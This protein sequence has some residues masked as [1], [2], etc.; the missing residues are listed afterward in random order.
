MKTVKIAAATIGVVLMLT[1][2][3]WPGLILLGA[4]IASFFLVG[5]G[6]VNQTNAV[7]AVNKSKILPPSKSQLE[8]EAKTS[9]NP[10]RLASL[11]YKAGERGLTNVHRAVAANP[12]T[13]IET[14]KDIIWDSHF[15]VKEVSQPL[16]IANLQRRVYLGCDCGAPYR[17][18]FRDDSWLSC[19]QCGH[20]IAVWEL[21]ESLQDKWTRNYDERARFNSSYRV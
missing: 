18:R 21:G 2:H 4:A 13:S 9:T 5:D 12:N 15:D 19:S 10:N 11:M 20:E 7:T 6:K 14:L 1:G 3:G 8:A 17:R 16:A